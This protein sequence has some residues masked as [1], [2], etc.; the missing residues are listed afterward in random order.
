[1]VE[2]IDAETDPKTLAAWAELTNVSVG[3]LRGICKAAGV[4]GK[5]SLD[6]ARVLRAVV[7]LQGH[8]WVPAAILDCRDP[9][10][11]RSL[12]SRTGCSQDIQSGDEAPSLQE[13][14]AR[15]SVLPRDG[16]RLRALRE[17]FGLDENSIEKSI[18]SSTEVPT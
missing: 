5:Q 2:V 12:L 15:Q 7:K 6:L 4:R 14:F 9:R 18:G 1:M 3:T 17:A 16:S 8:R 13:F 11:L 10:T